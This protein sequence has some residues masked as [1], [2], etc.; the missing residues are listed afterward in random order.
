[1][2][3]VYQT[4]GIRETENASVQPGERAGHFGGLVQ[5]SQFDAFF[6]LRKAVEQS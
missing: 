4:G 3:K 1:M 6:G 2:L 5:K